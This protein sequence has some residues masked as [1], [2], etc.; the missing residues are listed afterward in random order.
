MYR[1]AGSA[2]LYARGTLDRRLRD[3][4]TIGQHTMFSADRLAEIGREFLG[5]H[6]EGSSSF[7]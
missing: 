7:R 4:H 2:A 3:I 1:A 6:S 5:A